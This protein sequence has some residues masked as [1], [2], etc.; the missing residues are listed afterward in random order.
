MEQEKRGMKLFTVEA[1]YTYEN[2]TRV[3]RMR[4][5]TAEEVMRIREQIYSAGL[6]VEWN[7]G[8]WIIV[9]P[10]DLLR[11]ELFLQKGFFE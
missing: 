10:S 11:V 4:N 7:T 9:H 6:A 2:E 1:R 8:H 5:Q 3:W